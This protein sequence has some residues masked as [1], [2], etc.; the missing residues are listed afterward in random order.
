M[1]KA[2][3]TSLI[4][5]AAIGNIP[6]VQ[7][8]A[9]SNT[10]SLEQQQKITAIINKLVPMG[11]LSEENRAVLKEE[12]VKVFPSTEKASQAMPPIFETRRKK[13]N[14]TSGVVR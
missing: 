5:H 4:T 3:I 9:A 11:K 10:V 8:L 14:P 12:I 1:T 13:R 2:L 7:E 6:Y